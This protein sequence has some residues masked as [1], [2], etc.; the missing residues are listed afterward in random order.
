MLHRWFCRRALLFHFLL[1]VIATGCL[2]AGWWQVH[3][4]M[5]GNVLSYL[6]SVEWPLF[7]VVATIGWWQLIHEPPEMVEARRE[8][9][10]RRGQANPVAFD[11]EVLRRELSTHPELAATFPE[12]V[13]VFP[14]LAAGGP[15]PLEGRDAIALGPG[16]AVEGGA[17]ASSSP[18]AG[19]AL[20]SA[21]PA[22]REGPGESREGAAE[23]LRAYNDQLAGL[24]AGGRRKS[25]RN[26]HGH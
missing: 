10:R 19:S 17:P 24:A 18:G 5:D 26:P 11:R 25:W 12:L 20:V 8:E 9:R 4:A 1:A 22:P 21:G 23:R 16:E 14:E 13:Q 15:R 2:Y 6:Y 7:A 3:R